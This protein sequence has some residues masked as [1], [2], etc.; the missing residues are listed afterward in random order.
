MYRW[1]KGRDIQLMHYRLSKDC[2][3]HNLR[4]FI[5]TKY[6]VASYKVIIIHNRLSPPLT[7]LLNMSMQSRPRPRPRTPS[8]VDDPRSQRLRALK[9]HITGAPPTVGERS[10][11]YPAES[12]SSA[13]WFR[14]RPRMRPCC[15]VSTLTD[16]R[17]RATGVQLTD[18]RS[19]YDELSRQDMYSV[20]FGVFYQ[21]GLYSAAAAD[22][23]RYMHTGFIVPSDVCWNFHS[24]YIIY[25]RFRS[26]DDV[27]YTTRRRRLIQD[28]AVGWDG[29]SDR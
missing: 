18:G 1:N 15:G 3:R 21:L 6:R 9:D 7:K 25:T 28:S 27:E 23:I 19:E 14:S 4:M 10:A 24:R 2:D 5:I 22:Y 13:E 8:F 20:C 26:L 16:T 29:I 17:S 11:I 12:D